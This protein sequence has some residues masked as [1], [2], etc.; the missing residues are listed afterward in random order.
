MALRPAA[1]TAAVAEIEKERA[2]LL[3]K[4]SGKRDQHESRARQM[5]ARLPELVE[6][7]RQQI[8]Q[9]ITVLADE[10]VVHGARE[11]TRRLLVGGRITLAPN[12]AHTAVTG[13][14]QLVGLG[15]HVLQLAGWQRQRRAGSCKLSGSGGRI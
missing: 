3:A 2:E 7:Y 1:M 9:A 15:E 6:R 5:L 4:A 8:Q 10:N 11:E 14:V 13:P 12:T